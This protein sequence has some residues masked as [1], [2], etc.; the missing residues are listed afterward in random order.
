MDGIEPGI[1][2]RRKGFSSSDLGVLGPKSVRPQG[3]EGLFQRVGRIKDGHLIQSEPS[4][5][6]DGLGKE[7][8]PPPAFGSSGEVQKIGLKPLIERSR[9]LIGDKESWAESMAI[10]TAT[11]CCMP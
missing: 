4:S 9:G 10:A 11:R 1:R 5:P 2:G 6:G 3:G 7:S 8:P